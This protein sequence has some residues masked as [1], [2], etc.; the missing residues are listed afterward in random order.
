[1]QENGGCDTVRNE[2]KVRLGRRRER[3]EYDLE[4]AWSYQQNENR[5]GEEAI[6]MKWK[7]WRQTEKSMY[8]N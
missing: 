5:E 7:I 2:G 6:G 4:A 3:E 1:M 8:C